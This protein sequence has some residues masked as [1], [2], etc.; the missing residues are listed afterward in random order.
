MLNKQNQHPFDVN[1]GLLQE[2]YSFIGEF[3][4]TDCKDPTLGLERLRELIQSEIDALEYRKTYFPADWFTIKERVATM[5]GNFI[6][7]DDFQEICRYHGEND[8]QGRR[9]LAKF[10]HILGIALNYSDDPRL[11]DT[12]VLKPSWV[13]EGLYTLLRAGQKQNSGG[14][15]YPRDL[16]LVLDPKQYPAS[17]H[18]FLLRLMERCQLC[19]RLPGQEERYL[20]PELLGENQP[21]LKALLEAPGLGFRYQYE[22]LQ[23]GLL[24]HFIVQTHSHSEANPH[25][26]WRTGVVLARDG[27]RAVVRADAQERRVD[28]HITGPSERVRRDL[29]AIIRTSFEE[30][31]RD[32]KGLAVDERVPVPGEPGVTE[33]YKHLL[34]LEESGEEWCWPSGAKRKHKVPDL[35]NGVES[36]VERD[37]RRQREHD[38]EH[39]QNQTMAKKHAFISYCTDNKAE[40]AQLRDELITAGEPVWWDGEILGGQDWKQKIRQAMKDSYAVV[41]CLS[42]ELSDRVQ[43]GVYPEVA[44][45]ITLYRQQ[46][47][48]N[49]FLVPVRLSAC[50]IP[51]IEIDDTRTLDRLQCIQLFPE[52]TRAAGIQALLKALRASPNHP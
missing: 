30:Q 36:R 4:K 12:R 3:V 29:L 24:P 20:V 40:V 6:T 38:P 44:D 52:A 27:C 1:R 34:T 18:D 9:D 28:I 41:L 25:L 19:F 43:S 10:L 50:S 33:S 11:Q 5:P 31:Y 51:D 39:Q 2:K 23:E 16:A 47:P 37:L 8:L 35:L 48:G 21:D 26:R 7:W 49:T 17:R 45:A 22:V 32:L 14:V 13:T 46:A 42:K 15:L